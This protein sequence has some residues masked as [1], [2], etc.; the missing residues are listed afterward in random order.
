M[1]AAFPHLERFV[2]VSPHLDDGVFSLGAAAAWASRRDVDVT[3][4]TVLAGDPDSTAPAGRWDSRCG[5]ATAGEAARA[6]RREDERA[7]ALV[8]AAPVWLRF[9][10][11]QYP[12][13]ADDSTIWDALVDAIGPADVVL[14]PGSPLKHDDHRWLNALFLERGTP[15]GRLGLYREE[16]YA[17]ML[18]RYRERAP[19]VDSLAL[20]A[21]LGDRLAKARACRA[22]GS[23]LPLFG[24]LPTLRVL[25]YEFGQGGEHV[26]WVS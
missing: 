19:L 10:D 8:G 4:L 21:S 25:A 11:E 7:C 23:Q 18:P 17:A 5:F 16:P 14:V 6:R 24:R 12:R 1:A 26:A 20:P 9:S 13:G 15:A 3:M 22:Y 2:V